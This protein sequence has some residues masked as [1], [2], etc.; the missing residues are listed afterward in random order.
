MKEYEKIKNENRL[1]P[2][3]QD[4]LHVMS[5]EDYIK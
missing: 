5:M 2:T 1:R 3:I 4:L